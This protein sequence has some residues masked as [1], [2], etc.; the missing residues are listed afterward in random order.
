MFSQQVSY[1]FPFHGP[2]QDYFFVPRLRERVL[3]F[4]LQVKQAARQRASELPHSLRGRLLSSALSLLIPHM[5]VCSQGLCALG[6][7]HESAISFVYF[8]LV[9]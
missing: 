7:C 4:D 5:G 8:N 1:D 2:L 9:R 6:A 3:L